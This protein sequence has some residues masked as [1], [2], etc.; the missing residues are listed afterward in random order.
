MIV[1]FTPAVDAAYLQIIRDIAADNPFAA[2]RFMQRVRDAR[3]RLAKFPKLGHYIPEFP[4]SQHRQF[5]IEPYRFF[6]RID[7]ETVWIVAVWHGK[8][9]AA[10]PAPR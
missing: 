3:S 10:Q 6:Y 4:E 5:I 8:Q 2:R 1:R 9:V 7:G